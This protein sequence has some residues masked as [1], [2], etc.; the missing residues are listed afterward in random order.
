MDQEQLLEILSVAADAV[1][2]ALAKVD[3]WGLTDT[4]PGQYHLDV[5][6]DGAAL[7]VLHRAGL[8][9]MSEESGRTGGDQPIMV[10][11][12]PVDGSTNA[13]RGIPWYATSMCALDAE[14]PLAALVVNQATGARY[15]ATR[16]GGAWRDGQAICPT[17]TTRLGSSLVGL[18]GYP[19]RHLGWAQ[20]RAFGASA[21]ELCAVADGQLDAFC[22]PPGGRIF[23]WDYLGGMMVCREAGAVVAELND[24]ELVVRDGTERRPLA[25]ATPQLLSELKASLV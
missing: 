20:F 11:L 5:F 18:A 15:T 17:S 9:V 16:G 22:V 10:V 12:D 1:A 25:A 13:S 21:L 6:A 8:A 23:G 14:G 24:A 19:R 3:D 4:R 2:G 7:E